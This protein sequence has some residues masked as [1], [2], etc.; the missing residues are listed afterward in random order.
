MSKEVVKAIRKITSLGQQQHNNFI[1]EHF[2][3]PE[4]PVTNPL[5]QNRIAVFQQTIMSI[6]KTSLG[7]L[8]SDQALFARLYVAYQA[9]NDNLGKVQSWLPSIATLGDLRSENKA[10]LVLIMALKTCCC[11]SP[12][13]DPLSS[14]PTILNVADNQDQLGVLS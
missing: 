5:P 3:K 7:I 2:V 14:P 10:Q 6:H 1:E 4:K 13:S 11:A 9:R 8:K 12:N